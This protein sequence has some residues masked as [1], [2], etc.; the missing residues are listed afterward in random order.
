MG[1]RKDSGSNGAILMTRHWFR[2]FIETTLSCLDRRLLGVGPRRGGSV[3]PWWKCGVCIILL[4]FFVLSF[5]VLFWNNNSPLVSGHFPF[6][7]CHQSDCLPWFPIVS[8]CS[9][10]PPCVLIVCVSLCPLPVCSFCPRVR[11]FT[12]AL[13]YLPSHSVLL[14]CIPPRGILIL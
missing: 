1:L 8:T 7:M 14:H 13:P 9:L 5:P 4:G 11:T 10:F 12:L 2:T 3:T 6:L